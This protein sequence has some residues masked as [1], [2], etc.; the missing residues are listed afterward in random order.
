MKRT[1]P[2]QFRFCK[3][4]STGRE[5]SA[6]LSPQSDSADLRQRN[7]VPLLEGH[8]GFLPVRSSAGMRSALASELAANIQR[9]DPQNLHL[10]QVLH[11]VADLD[12]I[13]ARV[14]HNCVLVVLIALA[15]ALFGE[16]N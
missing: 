1:A 10:E 12:F 4:T 11:R 13:R 6:P 3:P 2:K 16:A 14:G 7:L 5:V 15:G 8:D 9:V